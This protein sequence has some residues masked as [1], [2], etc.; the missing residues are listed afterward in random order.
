MVIKTGF[1]SLVHYAVYVYVA[2]S[3]YVEFKCIFSRNEKIAY[4]QRKKFEKLL[5]FI[6]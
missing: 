1:D 3:S 2:W 5:N 6:I 4:F